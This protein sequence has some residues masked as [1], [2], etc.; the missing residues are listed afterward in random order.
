MWPHG[1]KPARLLCPWDFPGKNRKNWS[2]VRTRKLGSAQFSRSAKSFQSRPN[3][4]DPIEGSPPGSSIPG[5]LQARNWSGCHFL[6]QCMNVKSE[7]EVMSNSE[8]PWTVAYQAPLSMGF[9]WQEYWSGLP[10]PSPSVTQSCPTLSDPHG[11]QH[12]RLPCPSPPPRAYSDSR[13]SHR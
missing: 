12:A 2:S 4:C 13:P 9:S 3:L 8:T 5:I 11:L 7:S 10:F 1:L 6:L